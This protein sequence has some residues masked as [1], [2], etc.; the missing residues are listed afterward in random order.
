MPEILFHHFS[1]PIT[2]GYALWIFKPSSDWSFEVLDWDDAPV[3][4]HLSKGMIICSSAAAQGFAGRFYFLFAMLP[5]AVYGSVL[6][7]VTALI[8]AAH[9]CCPERFMKSWEPEGFV[10][11]TE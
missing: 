10:E 4:Q 5:S 11:Q 8:L 9:V 6:Y 2:A 7:G 1:N 3:L